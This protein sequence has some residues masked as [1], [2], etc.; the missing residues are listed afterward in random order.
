[1]GTSGPDYITA[2]S[3]KDWINGAGGTE[4]TPDTTN[5]GA[6]NDVYS[7]ADGFGIDTLEDSSGIDT[8][9]LS[10]ATGG[11]EDRPGSGMGTFRL[12]SG[13]QELHG[14]GQLL[15]RHHVREGGRYER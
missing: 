12:Q 10:A 6:G 3:G 8:V 2:L 14:Q 1:V 9:N 7:Y 15:F 11:C 13:V 5:G 4:T